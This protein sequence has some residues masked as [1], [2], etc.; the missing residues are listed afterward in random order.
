MSQEGIP[1]QGGCEEGRDRWAVALGQRIS[2]REERIRRA[3]EVAAEAVT[4]PPA[5]RQAWVAS[6]PDCLCPEFV[7]LMI[8]MARERR[9]EEP[10]ESV[11][12]AHLAVSAA[13]AY[14]RAG[15]EDGD[16]A[17][18]LAWAELG[19]AHRICGDLRRAGIA[20][21]HA[22]GR[23]RHS[24]DPLVRA[25]VYSLEAS[26]RDY[27]REFVIADRLLRRAVRLERRLGTK[28]AVVKLQIQRA[29]IARR[30]QRYSEA[31]ET[32]IPAL[33]SIDARR[34]PRLAVVGIHNLS[35]CLLQIGALQEGLA[36]LRRF[37][38]AY[39]AFADP[40]LRAR[41]AWLE[42]KA[43]GWAEDLDESEM[44]LRAVLER[45]AELD[46]PYEVAIVHLDL[47]EICIAQNRWTDVEK[48]AA[49]LLTICNASGVDTEGIAAIQLL[50]EAATRRQITSQAL[51]DA[52][53]AIRRNLAPRAVL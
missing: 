18:A 28:D 11:Q 25:E 24:S 53:T 46:C 39:I 23:M 41:R 17:R 4:V 30:T 3:Y 13:E 2:E 33:R 42:A 16:D 47:A 9:G 12:F 35:Y 52:M 43:L 10:R 38:P 37:R 19:N 26:Y 51:L 34:F 7:E 48:I 20:F 31:I 22:R 6:R 8:A 1:P 32:L 27:R 49:A 15:G 5:E 21:D 44:L 50:K 36:I 29:E 45:F 40:R 14:V